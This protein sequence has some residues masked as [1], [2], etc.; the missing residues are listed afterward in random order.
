MAA[1]REPLGP[2]PL[3]ITS[4]C[5]RGIHALQISLKQEKK[6]S[7]VGLVTHSRYAL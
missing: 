4:V 3:Y 6:G 7:A 1:Q 5:T 2:L